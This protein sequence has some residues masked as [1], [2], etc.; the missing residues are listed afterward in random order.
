MIDFKPVLSA[1]RNDKNLFNLNQSIKDTDLN[2]DLANKTSQIKQEP[3]QNKNDTE[4]SFSELEFQTNSM[5]SEDQDDSFDSRSNI[6]THEN[7][8]N[9]EDDLQN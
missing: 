2:T 6:T 5:V 9:D 7:K 1:S 4:K 8:Y 3:S